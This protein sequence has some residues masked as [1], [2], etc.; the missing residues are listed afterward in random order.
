VTNNLWLGASLPQQPPETDLQ[1]SPAC[2][3]DTNELH[4]AMVAGLQGGK[5]K[6]P[7]QT[8]EGKLV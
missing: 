1:Q 8:Q 3:A 6:E 4:I 5:A 7:K 2:Y